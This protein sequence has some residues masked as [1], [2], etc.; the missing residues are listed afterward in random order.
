MTSPTENNH[1]AGTTGSESDARSA[2]DVAFLTLD[3]DWHFTSLN[4]AAATLLGRP[5]DSLIGKVAWDEFPQFVGGASYREYHRAFAQR[6]AVLF[7]EFYPPDRWLEVHAYPI[8]AT[9]GV[10]FSDVTARKNAALE[11]TRVNRA[12]QLISR[13]NEALIRATH[14]RTL[15]DRI[16]R[17][18]VETGGYRAAW[19]A[20]RGGDEHAPL[21][22]QTFAAPDTDRAWPEQLDLG[23]SADGPQGQGPAAQAFRSGELVLV[24]DIAADASLAPLQHSAPKPGFAGAVY[25]PLRHEAE[26]FGVLALHASEAL[27]ATHDELKLLRELAANLAFG[28]GNIRSRTHQRQL[29]ATVLKVAASVSAHTGEKFFEQ[30]A[31]NMAEAVG[32]Y[33]AF[34]SRLLPEKPGMARTVIG[35]VAG[36]TVDNFDYTIAHAPCGRVLGQKQCVIEDAVGEQFPESAAAAMGARA[37]GGF[38]LDDAEGRPLGLLFVLFQHPV[39]NTELITSTLQIFAARAGSELERQETDARVREQAALLD[40][41]RDAI[42]VRSL[43][44]RILFWNKGAERLYGWTA[45][46]ALGRTAEDLLGDDPQALR[47][48]QPPVRADGDWDGEVGRRTKHG[49][50][51]TVETRWTL[52]SDDAG[53]PRAILS[54]DTDITRRKQVEQEIQRLALHDALT[55]LPNRVLMLDR[56]RH[57][58]ASAARGQRTGALLLI[59]LDDFK[60]VNDTLGHDR[61]DLLLQRAASRLQ[62]CVDDSD[63]VAR[64]GGDE[65]VVILENL[66]PDLD[67]AALRTEHVAADILSAM[68]QPFLLDD[69]ESFISCSIG[70]ALFSHQA[71]APGDLLKH[72]DMAMYRAKAA[73]RN[74]LRFF[75][76]A[77]QT[78]VLARSALETDLR[79]ALRNEQFALHFQ[80]Q[81]EE[82]GSISGA[83]ALLRWQHPTRGYLSPAIFIP[84]A[85]E[86]GVIVALGQW[87]LDTACAQMALWAQQPATAELCM[88]VN[89]SA[90]QLHHPGFV[91]GVTAALERAQADPHKLKIELTESLLVENVE[92]TITKM[93]AL[94]QLGVRFSLDDFGTGYSS[95][96][97]LKRLPLDQLKIDQSFVRDILTDPNDAA[98][99]RAVLAL[100]KNLGLS[101]IAE[102]VE[103]EEQRQLLAEC[104]CR[105]YQGYLFSPAISASEFDSFVAAHAL[106][107]AARGA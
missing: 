20:Y 59:D 4:A 18:A 107:R 84:L 61:G 66:S 69:G 83:E 27:C 19:V 43:E 85:E 91:T 87:V 70:A 21:S 32:A 46:E 58:V 28:I 42:V 29:E 44:H 17:I 56:L 76:P 26:T 94:R 102:G 96:A 57:A 33:G 105:A 63:T 71:S 30:L 6:C 106:Q 45:E 23:W 53:L 100:G 54:I 50:R 24:G 97:Y 52:I 86:T 51:L 39:R 88:S 40:K 67:K 11:L 77:M 14:E 60:A 75:D 89:V 74:T 65:F 98:I 13:C 8:G 34:V 80:P 22:I 5:R 81:V 1:D 79:H 103:T 101:V 12:L 99:A 64:L 68:T 73:G 15:L 35:V 55:G 48:A 25:L 16:C 104:G 92:T 7:E 10:Y 38:R 3:A 31:R 36:T 49:A 72:A 37:Y 95:L 93:T 62:C 90:R 9:L 41:A 78:A 2:G 82:N 47:E